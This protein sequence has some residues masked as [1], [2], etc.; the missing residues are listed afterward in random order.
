[1]LSI[2]KIALGVA[3]AVCGVH[4]VAADTYMATT[5]S[6]MHSYAYPLT[7]SET[8]NSTALEESM[9]TDMALIAKHF[10]YARTYYTS[11]YGVSVAQYA[12]KYGVKLY[13]GVYMTTESWQQDQIDAAVAAVQDYPDAIEAILVGNENLYQGFTSTN[14]LDIVS[15]IKESL[16]DA[17]SSV[18]FGTVQRLTEYLDSSYDSQTSD[19]ADNL[20]ILG[21]N[22]YPYFDDSYDA[23]EP[24]AIL[25]AS[26]DEMAAKFS[27]DQMLLTETGFPTAGDPSSLSPD[28]TPSLES[29]VQYFEAVAQW[30]GSGA[31]TSLKFWFDVFDRRPDDETMSEDLEKHF[32]IYTYDR[33]LKSSDYLTALG[34]SSGSSSSATTTT[35]TTTS[36]LVSTEST[37]TTSSSISTT[38]TPTVTTAATTSAPTSTTATPVST[39]S[40]P[41]TTTATPTTTTSST[42]SSVASES[43]TTTTDAT[44]TSTEAST[45]SDDSTPT[46]S[47]C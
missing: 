18:K 42:E 31:E 47:Y 45:A 41:A 43:T 38:E 13:L 46:S 35:T 22:I 6:P 9:D 28:I 21:V 4:A 24:T 11:Y 15:S 8:L 26:W 14:I 34:E 10:G 40:A 16:G 32:G 1:M 39:T 2:S 23:S 33:E 29:S 27:V 37:S 12:A 19:L 5:Y 17:A 36:T 30:S 20:D 3:A 44:T 7:S 25:D